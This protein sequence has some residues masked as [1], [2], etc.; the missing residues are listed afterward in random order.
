MLGCWRRHFRLFL[1]ALDRDC[2]PLCV[3]ADGVGRTKLERLSR[4]R[5]RQPQLCG[6]HLSN[7]LQLTGDAASR[8][9]L[10]HSALQASVDQNGLP[11]LIECDVCGAAEQA[12]RGLVNVIRRMDGRLRFEKAIERGSLVCHRHLTLV[13]AEGAAR[14]FARVQHR[15]RQTLINDISQAQLLARD[16]LEALLEKALAYLGTPAPQRQNC[17]DES[18]SL[19]AGSEQLAEAASDFMQWDEEQ[20]LVHLSNIESEVASLRY[21][22]AALSEENRRFKPAHAAVEAIR[23][24]LERDRAELRAASAKEGLAPSNSH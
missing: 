12:T 23:H 16:S 10:V 17:P 21:R 4:R 11:R 9:V 5:G 7:L 18:S 19:E 14:A 8:V 24:D 13:A 3:V 22:N 20:K 2:C 15:K 6:I 1:N